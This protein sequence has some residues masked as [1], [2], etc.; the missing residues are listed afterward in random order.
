MRPDAHTQ[1][2]ILAC[3]LHLETM[4]SRGGFG[5]AGVAISAIQ[6]QLSSKFDLDLTE[7]RV[8]SAMERLRALGMVSKNRSGRSVWYVSRPSYFS[9]HLYSELEGMIP[10]GI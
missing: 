2:K 1:K 9:E 8:R 4:T 3:F 5:K 10:D 7:A 6:D